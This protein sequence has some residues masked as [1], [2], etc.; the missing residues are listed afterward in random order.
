MAVRVAEKAVPTVPL[1][2]DVVEILK[3]FGLG[4]GAAS[5][6]EMLTKT[7]IKTAADQSLGKPRPETFLPPRD[8]KANTHIT[9]LSL[10]TGNADK[11]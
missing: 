5:R 6:A 3:I 10:K 9:D 2:R 4:L 7:Q 11:S 1:G 8:L